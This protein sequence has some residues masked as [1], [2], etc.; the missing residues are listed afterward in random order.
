M[1]KIVLVAI[2]LTVVFFSW[3]HAKEKTLNQFNSNFRSN[4]SELVEARAKIFNPETADLY[5][6]QQFNYHREGLGM[7]LATLGITE[8]QMQ[9]VERN[10]HRNEAHELYVVMANYGFDLNTYKKMR[11]EAK[12]AN[13]SLT[14]I[15]SPG[16]I[17]IDIRWRENKKVYPNG[18]RPASSE[19]T[20]KFS[21]IEALEAQE[22]KLRSQDWETDYQTCIE[23]FPRTYFLMVDGKSK[24]LAVN[25]EDDTVTVTVEMP[26]GTYFN[27]G[28]WENPRCDHGYYRLS[29][30]TFFD[31]DGRVISGEER[32]WSPSKS[33][34][35][36][37]TFIDIQPILADD[38]LMV[39]NQNIF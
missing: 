23:K 33:G 8:K 20:Q 7:S 22:E 35:V 15:I 9:E 28:S 27:I 26:V 16:Q 24:V 6:L 2:V 31:A 5:Y 29:N 34:Y 17:R 36:V 13:L 38:G 39:I 32:D 3:L 18:W 37:R 10:C 21:A 1:K 4:L 30:M 19:E 12:L 11:Q 14:D 25:P